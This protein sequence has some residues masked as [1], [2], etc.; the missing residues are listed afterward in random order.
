MGLYQYVYTQESNGTGT[1]HDCPAL[2][3][4]EVVLPSTAPAGCTQTGLSGDSCSSSVM[5]TCQGTSGSEKEV[6]TV[7]SNADGTVINGTLR[8]NEF[9]ANG[10]LVCIGSY[11]FT[12]T[13]Q[14]N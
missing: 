10:N 1:V 12:A 14:H 5:A 8:T 2:Q 6:V 13:K 11:T 3:N 7:D 9:D 4:K